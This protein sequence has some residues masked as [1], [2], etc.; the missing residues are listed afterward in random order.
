MISE[1][2]NKV[3]KLIKGK[4]PHQHEANAGAR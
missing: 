1:E 3:F 2:K 4:I